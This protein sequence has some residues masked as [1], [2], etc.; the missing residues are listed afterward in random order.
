MFRRLFAAFVLIWLRAASG[1][2]LKE[3]KHTERLLKSR[4]LCYDQEKEFWDPSLANAY[5]GNQMLYSREPIVKSR[6]KLRSRALV[7]SSSR[8]RTLLPLM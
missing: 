7:S 3:S 8:H 4:D 5:M 6:T 2:Y 1:I